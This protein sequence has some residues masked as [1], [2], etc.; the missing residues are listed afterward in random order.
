[1]SEDSSTACSYT[2]VSNGSIDKILVYVDDLSI[3]S[4]G[5][6][7]LQ[8]IADE[9]GAKCPTVTV[10]TGLQHDFL[11]IHWDFGTQGQAYIKDIYACVQDVIS[12]FQVI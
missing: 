7:T 2:R 9:L 5:E 1:M 12:K 8:T 6:D 10:K 11:G 3:T 4:K